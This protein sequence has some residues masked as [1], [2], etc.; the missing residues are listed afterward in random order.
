MLAP[1]VICGGMQYES[2]CTPYIEKE[3]KLFGSQQLAVF[4]F[5]RVDSVILQFLPSK[6][7]T[8]AR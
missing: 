3:I 5:R 7:T 8:D 1:E 6:D 4:R 2:G